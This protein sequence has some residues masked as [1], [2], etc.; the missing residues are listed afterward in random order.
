MR[1]NN[2][3]IPRPC[4][5]PSSM[6]SRNK[7]LSCIRVRQVCPL[8]MLV[9]KDPAEILTGKL[10]NHLSEEITRGNFMAG[11]HTKGSRICRSVSHCIELIIILK[12]CAV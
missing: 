5:M 3:H 4:M 8:E 7:G 1:N 10:R 6:K 9:N 12:I 11:G 2:T